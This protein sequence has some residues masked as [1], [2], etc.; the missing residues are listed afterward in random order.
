MKLIASAPAERLGL[1]ELRAALDVFAVSGARAESY[2]VRPFRG[3]AVAPL[4]EPGL[5]RWSGLVLVRLPESA[6]AL[7]AA[8]QLGWADSLVVDEHVLADT[9]Q[10]A[11]VVRVGFLRRRPELTKEQFADH[12]LNVHGPLVLAHDPLFVRYVANVIT[13]G[14]DTVDGV[15]EQHFPDRAAWTEHDR[16]IVHERPRV[17]ADI[18]TFL[19]GM[20]QLEA[21]PLAV[22]VTS[23]E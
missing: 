14:D 3:A 15:V 19:A 10:P 8:Q 5:R 12:W 1:D 11:A 20:G 6:D 9:G 4:A 22:A 23:P 21:M 18:P 2:A 17:A 16:R 13:G 7:A